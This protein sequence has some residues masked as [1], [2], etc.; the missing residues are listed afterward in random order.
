MSIAQD[1]QGFLWLA[2]NNGLYRYDRYSLS[3]L[4]RFLQQLNAYNRD[5]SEKFMGK[6]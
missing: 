3:R 6:F 1:N 4:P 2:S 5:S